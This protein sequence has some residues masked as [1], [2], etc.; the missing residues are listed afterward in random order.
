MPPR[1]LTNKANSVKAK[2]KAMASRPR[3]RPCKMQPGKCQKVKPLKILCLA[4]TAGDNVILSSF[5]WHF[6][7]ISRGSNTFDSTGLIEIPRKSSTVTD[8]LY[9]VLQFLRTGTVND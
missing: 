4:N 6:Q 1:M 9:T 8:L 7:K 2:A 3:S 5:K